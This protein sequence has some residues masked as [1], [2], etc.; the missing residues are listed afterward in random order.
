MNALKG[1]AQ[2]TSVEA[3]PELIPATTVRKSITPD[4]LICLDDG[5][6]FK[7]LKRHIGAL[8]MTPD[9]YRAKWNL[10]SDYSMVAPNYSATRSALARKIGLGRKPVEEVKSKATGTAR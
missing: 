10:P 8:G 2:G 6:K 5:K 9:Q 3:K 7:S 1:I 4:Y